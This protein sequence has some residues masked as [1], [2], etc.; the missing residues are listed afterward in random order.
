[1]SRWKQRVRDLDTA[2]RN[3]YENR[4][5]AFETAWADASG[6][7]PSVEAF[8]EEGAHRLPLLVHLVKCDLEFRLDR[9]ELRQIEDYLDRFPELAADA[10]ALLELAL[11]ESQWTEN[12]PNREELVRRFPI[13]ASRIASPSSSAHPA[14]WSLPPD[15]EYLGEL[16][17]GNW[18]VVYKVRHRRMN[19]IEALKAVD[20]SKANETKLRSRVQRL[21]DEIPIAARLNHPNIVHVYGDGERDGIPYFA[22]EYCPGGS[23]RA[24][25]DR[26]PFSPREAASLIR[27]LAVAV[28][29]IHI[30]GH[31]HRDLK[32]QNVMFG[33]EEV[34]K[35]ADFGLALAR[36]D[37]DR[38]DFAGT[39]LYMA[40]EQINPSRGKVDC[41]ADVYA[42][43]VILHEMLTQKP[44]LTGSTSAELFRIIREETPAPPIGA[45][46]DLAAIIAKCLAKE[47]DLRYPSA[48]ALADDLGFFLD[49]GLVRARR[50]PLVRRLGHWIRR[51]RIASLIAVWVLVVLATIGWY[52][53]RLWQQE[54]DQAEERR[55][56]AV[57]LAEIERHRLHEAFVATARETA[58]RGNYQAALAAYDRAIADQRPD[59]LHLRVERLVGY[60]ATNQ[61]KCLVAELDALEKQPLAKLEPQVQLMRAAWLVCDVGRQGEGRMLAKQALERRDELFSDADRHFAEGIAADRVGAGQRAFEA[62]VRSDPFHYLGSSC[63]VVALAAVGDRAK[64]KQQMTFLRSVFPDSPM[65]DL[66]EAIIAVTEGDRATLESKLRELR[67][68]MHAEQQDSVARMRDFLMTILDLQDLGVRNIEDDLNFKDYMATAVLLFKARSIG[69]LSSPEPMGLPIPA[70]SLYWGRLLEIAA[71]SVEV[72]IRNKS[73]P[74]DQS[75]L[76]RLE[77]INSDHPDALLLLMQGTVQLRLAIGPINDGN[78]PAVKAALKKVS[79]F[80]DAARHAPSLTPRLPTPYVASARGF[81]SD[82]AYARFDPNTPPRQL[83]DLRNQAIQLVVEGRRWPRLR[84]EMA[85]MAVS[86]CIAPLTEAQASEW[87][88][89]TEKGKNAYRD[90]H[91]AIADICSLLLESWSLEDASNPLIP[92]L[93]S[94]VKSSENSSG[95]LKSR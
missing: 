52:R 71:A 94:R 68:K 64:A 18:G 42:L 88:I 9:G 26:A 19:R 47:P 87:R 14:E 78:V 6:S 17:R 31:I 44:P 90:R 32:P 60:F 24:R 83:V 37:H 23:L 69:T 82:L 77:A 2:H 48:Q 34:P 67:D 56:H 7:A 53:T 13:L 39:P 16:G 55:D 40:P 30:F 85:T 54:I 41:T 89:D 36:E 8:L 61:I 79:E 75:T 91:Q 86:L 49:G 12:Q 45:P 15:Y 73:T 57:Q 74:K 58:R 35:I 66:T 63:H 46:P 51:N 25:I 59:Q 29:H 3:R 84:Q 62:A 33:D 1:M 22:M 10:D 43:G 38:I 92:S 4:A 93:R 27:T 65:P 5:E 70:V 11:G 76:R 28:H 80:A 95:L 21:R 20:P 81:M 50:H 72:G